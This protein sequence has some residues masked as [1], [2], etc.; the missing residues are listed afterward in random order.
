MLLPFIH[1]PELASATVVSSAVAI[2]SLDTIRPVLWSPVCRRHMISKDTGEH[3]LIL[4]FQ[5]CSTRPAALRRDQ[6][7]VVF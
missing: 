4:G 7:G 6:C 1:Y 3:S 5:K 2:T